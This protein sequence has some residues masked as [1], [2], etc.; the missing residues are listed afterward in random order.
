MYVLEGLVNNG[1]KVVENN[2]TGLT[3]LLLR[4][5]VKVDGI[6]ADG[7]A[8]VQRRLQV[9]SSANLIFYLVFYIMRNKV[10][11]IVMGCGIY[12]L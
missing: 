7:D 3:E 5:M 8:K 12:Y 6:T 11:Y 2:I 9:I 10:L 4:Q 1:K